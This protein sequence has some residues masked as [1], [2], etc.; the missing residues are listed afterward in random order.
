MSFADTWP[1]VEALWV[2]VLKGL[3]CAHLDSAEKPAGPG[4]AG[5]TEMRGRRGAVS[6]SF[7]VCGL[8]LNVVHKHIP[9][10]FTTGSYSGIFP[11]N[12]IIPG[13][14]C[15]DVANGSG[16]IQGASKITF[17][18]PATLSCCI[19]V[20]KEKC[21]DDEVEIFHTC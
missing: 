10:S 8:D 17:P 3:Q 6:T 15:G 2:T 12:K 1:W 4:G 13:K 16:D 11:H 14:P 21:E 7:A 18:V 20:K 5:C 19:C 9:P